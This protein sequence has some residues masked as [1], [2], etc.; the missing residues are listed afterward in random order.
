MYILI[1][2][3]SLIAIV[4][5]FR[6]QVSHFIIEHIFDPLKMTGRREPLRNGNTWFRRVNLVPG[7][8]LACKNLGHTH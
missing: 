8:I 7:V 6:Y 3:K 5:Y 1:I 2:S 4:L